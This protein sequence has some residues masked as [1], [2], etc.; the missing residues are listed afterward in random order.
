[1]LIIHAPRFARCRNFYES[2]I[3]HFKPPTSGATLID[4]KMRKSTEFPVWLD[5]PETKEMLKGKQVSEFHSVSARLVTEE[6]EAM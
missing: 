3:G 2:A 5:K 4:P 6:C 1:M